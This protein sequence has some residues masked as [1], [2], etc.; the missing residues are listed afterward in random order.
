MAELTAPEWATHDL[1]CATIPEGID[2]DDPVLT[3]PEQNRGLFA[4]TR[5]YGSVS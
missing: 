5:S 3:A 1:P 4:G 2:P